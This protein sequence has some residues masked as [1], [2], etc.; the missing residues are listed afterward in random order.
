MLSDSHL[1]GHG[2][3]RDGDRQGGTA[4]IC[5]RQPSPRGKA[6]RRIRIQNLI[7]ITFLKHCDGFAGSK[8]TLAVESPS[9]D[10]QYPGSHLCAFP[11]SSKQRQR[12]PFNHMTKARA[13]MR[14][15][16]PLGDRRKR[17]LSARLLL[18]VV[19]LPTSTDG[20]PR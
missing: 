9:I 13:D 17:L 5:R 8:T 10:Q 14:I 19:N 7:H 6:T 11:G 18:G 4:V 20:D 12:A 2:G 3:E 15:F 16:P 1:P